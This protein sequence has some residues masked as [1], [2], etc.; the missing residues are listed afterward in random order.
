MLSVLRNRLN[1]SLQ[2]IRVFFVTESMADVKN[3]LSLEEL[4]EILGFVPLK[5]LNVFRKN[6]LRIIYKTEGNSRIQ[7]LRDE[8]TNPF[9]ETEAS[10]EHKRLAL[11]YGYV[12]KDSFI[13]NLIT[14]VE[15]YFNVVRYSFAKDSEK[16]IS[17]PA[18]L[19][20]LNITAEPVVSKPEKVD[21][22]AVVKENV[23]S[24]VTKKLG[25]KTFDRQKTAYS[26]NA[27]KMRL[28]MLPEIFTSVADTRKAD[29]AAGKRRNQASNKDVIDLYLRINGNN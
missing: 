26:A 28:G 12:K 7:A 4:N 27:T 2:Q 21:A 25:A 29:R 23:L 20:P 17:L 8:I 14:K 24:F 3:R 6:A 5:S 13:K 18:D 1:V 19:K 16:T 10:K 11:K 15:N 22:K 9:F